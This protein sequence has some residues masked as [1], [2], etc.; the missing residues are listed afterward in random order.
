MQLAHVAEP[1]VGTWLVVASA[2][3]AHQHPA[4]L[5]NLRADP[6]ARVL[7][8]GDVE[9][10]VEARE[11]DPHELATRWP[12]IVQVIPQMRVYRRRTAR[13][14]PVVRLTPR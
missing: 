7:L 12:E 14:L 11:L 2:M 10:E 5:L 4:W 6:H 1:G 8:P 9:L 3:G 13:T